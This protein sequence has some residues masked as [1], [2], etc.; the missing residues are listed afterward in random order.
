M[1][2]RA[3]ALGRAFARNKESVFQQAGL[4]ELLHKYRHLQI[5]DM[6]A[7]T[8]RL[9]MVIDMIK[10]APNMT[11]CRVPVGAGHL[12][13]SQS[14]AWPGEYVPK[15]PCS[16]VPGGTLDIAALKGTTPNQLVH[17]TPRAL[18]PPPQPISSLPAL[19]PCTASGAPTTI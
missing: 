3:T 17:L 6:C 15:R 2:T 4:Q 10:A 14:V 8:L 19:G 11:H 16:P 18:S 12:R 9:Q 7:N 5:A 13:P 1:R